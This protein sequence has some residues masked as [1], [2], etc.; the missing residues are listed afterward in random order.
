MLPRSILLGN[1]LELSSLCVKDTSGHTSM[2]IFSVDSE[3]LRYFPGSSGAF[4]ILL[5]GVYSVISALQ[6]CRQ[7]DEPKQLADE[8]SRFHLVRQ[9]QHSAVICSGA[10]SWL[11]NYG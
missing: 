5:Y 1:T 7:A 9:C 10:V 2:S 3:L 4:Q 8:A 11:T 6:D